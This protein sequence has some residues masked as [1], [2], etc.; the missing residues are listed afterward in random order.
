ME[1]TPYETLRNIATS[2]AIEV[3]VG[4]DLML[5]NLR[6]AATGQIPPME[7]TLHSV[8]ESGAP[9]LL[10]ASGTALVV[11]GIQR[12]IAAMRSHK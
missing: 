5:D 9:S 11:H 6:L 10:A 3:Y 4:G 7:F 1:R 12:G 8:F 2:P